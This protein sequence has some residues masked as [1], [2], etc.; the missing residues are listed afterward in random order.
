LLFI[1][2]GLRHI[3]H[4]ANVSLML[5]SV[6]GTRKLLHRPRLLF[7]AWKRALVMAP[8]RGDDLGALAALYLE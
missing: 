8:D 7:A 2:I 5:R 4:T 6:A 3:E 1:G